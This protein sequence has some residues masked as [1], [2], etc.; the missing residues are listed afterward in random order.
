MQTRNLPELLAPAGSAS[1]LE[2]AICGG[3]DAVYF[4]GKAFNARANAKNFDTEAMTAAFRLCH[5][6]GVKAYVTLNTQ[7]YDRE[8]SDVLAYVRELYE[9]GADALI[10]ADLGVASLIRRHFP[11]LPIHASTQCTAHNREGVAFLAEQGFS[12]VVCARE[13]S[14][15]QIRTLCR[16]GTEIEM[17]VHG[18]HCVSVSG[19]CL[20]SYALGGR[21]GNR[22][23]C[24]QPCR[25]PYKTNKDGYPLS[26]K[27]MAL[28]RH[29][30]EIIRM[31]VASLKIEGRMKSPAYV[32]GVT[33][34]Y[35]RLLDEDRG[36]TREEEAYLEGLFSR[37]GFTDGYYRA[38]MD[39][40]ML[41]VR[42]EENKQSGREAEEAPAL[43]RVPLTVRA[44]IR[45]G[46]P[47]CLTLQ[48]P[49]GE[50]TVTGEEPLV[51]QNAPM[52]A[53]DYEK[54]LSKFGQTPF[55]VTELHVECDEGLMVP[56][57]RL[58]ALRRQAVEALVAPKR[59]PVDVPD[60]PVFPR[61]QRGEVRRMA[62]YRR[63]EQVTAAAKAFFDVIFLPADRYDPVA[64]GVE[65][66][67]V[68]Y[69]NE[70]PEVR[71]QLQ[72]A[73]EAGAEYALVSNVGQ[74]AVARE[75]GFRLVGSH[76]FNVFNGENARVLRE[77]MDGL[78]LS[79]EL[80]LRQARDFPGGCGLM[81]YGKL[82]L[83]YMHR[84]IIR[85]VPGGCDKCAT[86]L[87]DRKGTSF[88]VLGGFGH[89]C[90]IYNSV[91][92]YMADRPAELARAAD[93][94][95]YLFTDETPALCDQILAA[96]RR[97]L[98]AK[99]PIRRIP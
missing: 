41:G 62:S 50:V 26:L 6:H 13:L 8:L 10:V 68:V 98:P 17:F 16:G 79:A 66:P 60:A 61:A 74:I 81:V 23:E 1:A 70:W 85:D 35:R 12:R 89:R 21:S 47:V 46:E 56:V 29:I 3:A 18:A 73:R 63:A 99:S 71:R 48:S 95:F 36:P 54:N 92:T 87:T 82:P 2:A 78:I 84:C 19:Q 75:L 58:N 27:D 59:P 72:D 64:G 30:P 90:T 31:G 55:E 24:A 22:G 34:V 77:S 39:R 65:L 88:P 33:S 7:I 52:A 37:C 51:A 15:E 53:A 76:R 9:L 93:L 94:H 25:L 91:P 49:H 97:A 43:A 57:S 4:G 38:R 86:V 42:T 14:A 40:T 69:D 20:M 67:P 5:A 28:A 32:Y 96:H 80:T 45:R 44:V 11:A 83:M